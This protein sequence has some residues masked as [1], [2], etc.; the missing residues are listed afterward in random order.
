M[1]ERYVKKP[2]RDVSLKGF[3]LFLLPLPLLPA[4]VT[5][6]MS[7]GA[8]TMLSRLIPA[9]LF[10]AGAI[11]MRSGLIYEAAYNKRAVAKAPAPR[12]T[13]ASILTAL[14]AAACIYY[15]VGRPV[16]DAAVA[17]LLAFAGCWLAYGPDPR[18]DKAAK[19]AQGYTTA[20][21]VA[22]LEEAESKLVRIDTARKDIRNAELGGRLR[23]IIGQARKI[24]KVIEED[25]RDIRRARKFLNT[26]LDGA[27][28]VSEGYA[29]THK[30]VDPGELESNFRNVLATIEDVFDEQYDKLLQD[31]VTDLDVQ[32][33]VLKLQLE[34]E[35][36]V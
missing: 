17:G 3:L 16:I 10:L 21:V 28:K 12:K 31:D 33:E 7:G 11:M 5:S 24:L 1:A 13:L 19:A 32:I 34:R 2:P 30:M 35:G 15:A 18:R 25:P 14:G 29:R 6:F 4:M 36:V 20:E 23:K 27:L 9:L 22:A 26:Y 8:G